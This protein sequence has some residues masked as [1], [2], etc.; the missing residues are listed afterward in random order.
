MTIL[1]INHIII[2]NFLDQDTYLLATQQRHVLATESELS[3]PL[4]TNSTSS[5]SSSTTTNDVIPVRKQL[6]NYRSPSE[7]LGI[8]VGNWLDTTISRVPNRLKAIQKYG[9]YDNALKELNLPRREVLD[10]YKQHTS[11]CKDS[12]DAVRKSKTLRQVTKLVA[13]FPFVMKI[14]LLTT[15]A[16]TTMTSPVLGTS[17]GNSLVKF[18]LQ[19]L[20]FFTKA[21]SMLFIWTMSAMAI[22]F[23]NKFE[24]EFEFKYT[25]EYRDNDMDKIPTVWMDSV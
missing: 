3:L 16:T 5:S 22:F 19:R 15:S 8:K 12:S 18:V 9:G 25:N 24:K 11:I 10:R 20:K 13:L 17:S 23:T 7:K 4:Q 14:L 2:N 21:S 1:F 6:Y